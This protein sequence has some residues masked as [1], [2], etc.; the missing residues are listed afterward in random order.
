[1]RK[2]GHESSPWELRPTE[3]VA[4]IGTASSGERVESILEFARY[5]FISRLAF[6]HQNDVETGQSKNRDGQYTD[7]SYQ[8]Q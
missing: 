6:G 7:Q 1:M 5:L 3:S 4:A 2:C 8:A